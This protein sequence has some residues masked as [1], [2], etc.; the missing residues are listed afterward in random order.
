L[1]YRSEKWNDVNVIRCP[2]YVPKKVTGVHRLIH[3]LSFAFFSLPV[4]LFQKTKHP[5]IVFAVAPAII[6]APTVALR[7]KQN[8][9]RN[10]LH[11]Q[12]FE[13]DA[14]LNLGLITR[15]RFIERMAN[16]WESRVFQRFGTLSTISHAMVNRLIEKGVSAENIKYFPNWVNTDLIFPLTGRNR[17]RDEFQFTSSDVVVLYSG[18]IGQKQGIETLINAARIISAHQNIH[19]VICGEGPRIA[20]L[21][22]SV[23]GFSN[24]HFLPLQPSE[25]LNELL[26]MADMHVLPQKAAAA[27]LVMPSKLL[28]MLASGRPVIAA[29]N[30]GSELYEIVKNVGLVTAPEDPAKLAE[31]IIDLS[32]DEELRKILGAKGR[33]YVV[34]HFSFEKILNVM[35]E[36]LNH[37]SSQ[38]LM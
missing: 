7:G 29:C 35:N 32:E 24:I 33:D 12:D 36:N 16:S 18:S 31:K 30:E 37:L 1:Q 13:I 6:L 2:V 21:Q 4:I 23:V 26:N 10:W 25:S 19:L 28:G 34:K 20:Q 3:L 38:N 15:S 8:R 14:A 11:I 17:Y 22:N 9:Y 5:D 27:D